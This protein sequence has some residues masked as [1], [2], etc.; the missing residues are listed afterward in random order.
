MD[1]SENVTSTPDLDEGE[2]GPSAKPD[3]KNNKIGWTNF[4]V[5]C[6]FAGWIVFLIKCD[7]SWITKPSPK[8]A[9]PKFILDSIHIISI[10]RR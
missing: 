10:E 5:G 8:L 9:P 3:K 6:I 2:V 1:S 4:F 7:K